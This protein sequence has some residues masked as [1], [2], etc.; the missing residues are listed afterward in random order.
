MYVSISGEDKILNFTIDSITGRLNPQ[1]EIIVS[2]H[3]SGMVFSPDQRFIYV[4]RK[5]DKSISTFHRNVET[6]ELS[7]IGTTTVGMEPD[8]VAIDRKGQYLFSTYFMEGKAGI[9]PIGGD[10]IVGKEPLQ[11][12]TSSRG[13]HSVQTDPSNQFAFFPHIAGVGPN[14]ILQYKFDE[15][16]GHFTPNNPDRLIPDVDAGPRH[17][18]FHPKLD[19]LFFDNEE[20]SSVTAYHLN[21]SNGT[22]SAFQTVS[23]LPD[24]YK[25]KNRCADIKI[26]PTGGSLYVSNRGL[27][28][29]AC[30]S[31]NSQTGMLTPVG[32]V[33]ADAEVRSFSLDPAGN[34]LFAA[35][36]ATGRLISYRVNKVTAELQQLETYNVGKEPWWVLITK[37]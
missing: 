34:F 14:V 8:W 36:L 4:G 5:G 33:P 20:G 28:T 9:Y 35:G 25:L 3:P 23:T 22:L 1:G 2:G 15:S 31:V 32:R 11:W 16:T 24:D 17:F 30:Y 21:R 37:T 27:N 26:S 7:L 13:L 12:I 6:G 29:I 19:I 18:C 10:G